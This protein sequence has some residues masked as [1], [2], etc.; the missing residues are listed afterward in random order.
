LYLFGRQRVAHVD[1]TGA[2]EAV[3]AVHRTHF[4]M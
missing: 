1:V 2:K 3:A 4:G